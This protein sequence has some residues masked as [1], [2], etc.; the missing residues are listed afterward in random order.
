M[1]FANP[2][3]RD[4]GVFTWA[5]LQAAY[6]NGGGALAALPA[7]ITA[8][9][10]DWG[11]QF[12]PNAAGARWVIRSP[13]LLYSL[14]S[15]AAVN[16]TSET[17]VA[18]PPIPA[19]LLGAGA[20][21]RVELSAHDNGTTTSNWTVYLRIGTAGTTADASVAPN[22]DMSNAA[23]RS[24][25]YVRDLFVISN[26]ATNLFGVPST[27]SGSSPPLSGQ[28]AA[29]RLSNYTIPDLSSSANIL[30][31][32]VKGSDAVDTLTLHNLQ[33]W[34]MGNGS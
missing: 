28:S 8:F 25:G 9:V 6:P 7:G 11:A 20:R 16:S 12:A 27:W 31:V 1:K 3:S 19:A 18:Q 2:F 24:F 15:P 22:L 21:I 17:L 10:S 5:E 4:L 14:T 23:Q 34:I 13:M 30:S 26:T 33:V 29:T 32:G